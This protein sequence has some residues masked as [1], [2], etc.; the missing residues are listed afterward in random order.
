MKEERLTRTDT[1]EKSHHHK[2]RTN[3]ARTTQSLWGV[4]VLVVEC[5]AWT[6][7]CRRPL[8]SHPGSCSG[9]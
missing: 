2:W 4:Q 9:S 6:T 5:H 7:V 3:S 8:R 1:S